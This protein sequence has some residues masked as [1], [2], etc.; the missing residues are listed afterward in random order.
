M[1]KAL[2]SFCDKKTPEQQVFETLAPPTLN[3]ALSKLMPGLTAK[4]FRTYNASV[5]LESEL[6]SAESLEGALWFMWCC[7]CGVC[8]MCHV[9]WRFVLLTGE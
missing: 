2:K 1:Y 6:P 9:C 3:D 4:V 7:L 5:T 8:D